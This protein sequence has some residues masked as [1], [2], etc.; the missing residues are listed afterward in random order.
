MLLFI[1]IA[2]ITSQITFYA[3]RV[4]GGLWCTKILF[5]PNVGIEFMIVGNI[6]YA[7][8]A[9]RLRREPQIERSFVLLLEK[10]GWPFVQ[11]IDKTRWKSSDASF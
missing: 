1:L 4:L 6:Q 5:K 10:Y 2:I 3:C 7:L 11:I 9:G 8:G